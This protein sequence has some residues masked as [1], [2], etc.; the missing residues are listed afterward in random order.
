MD[1]SYLRSA[2]SV[3]TLLSFVDERDDAGHFIQCPMVAINGKEDLCIVITT[4]SKT[5]WTSSQRGV[6]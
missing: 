4:Y 2:T 6:Q 3:S 1:G 5:I